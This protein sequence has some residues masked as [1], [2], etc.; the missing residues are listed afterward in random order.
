MP[1]KIIMPMKASISSLVTGCHACL[2]V[3]VSSNHKIIITVGFPDN[4]LPDVISEKKIK[5]KLS[6]IVLWIHKSSRRTW[7]WLSEWLG[8]C[9][10]SCI[11]RSALRGCLLFWRPRR[12]PRGTPLKRSLCPRLTRAPLPR[13]RVLVGLTLRSR[14]P[15][16]LTSSLLTCACL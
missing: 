6:W 4:H 16:S 13:P 2:F 10:N 1:I 5:M 7:C 11:S 15:L 9:V 8:C 14:P 12:D 3:W